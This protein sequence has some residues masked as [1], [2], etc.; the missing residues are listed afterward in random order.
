M[1]SFSKIK[2]FKSLNEVIESFFNIKNFKS[3]KKVTEFFFQWSRFIM[4][5]WLSNFLEQ[6]FFC[7]FQLKSFDCN[8]ILIYMKKDAEDISEL[9]S[10]LLSYYTKKW[11]YIHNVRSSR[12]EFSAIQL[13]KTF[14]EIPVEESL[15]CNN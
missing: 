15:C 3:R 14:S 13:F 12:P 10:E 9:L 11:F 5:S 2:I 4:L 8:N 7:Q 6:Y 1:D